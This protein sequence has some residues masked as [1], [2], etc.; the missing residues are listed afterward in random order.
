MGFYRGLLGGNRR[1]LGVFA[2]LVGARA[3]KKVIAR[4]EEV[5]AV[6]TLAPGQR[7]TIVTIDPV[8]ERAAARMAKAKRR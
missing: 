1:W 6:E 4:T 2:V 7:L 3:A 5:A 8:A